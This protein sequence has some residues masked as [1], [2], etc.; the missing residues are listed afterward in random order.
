M[1]FSAI[2]GRPLL[3][4]RGHLVSSQIDVDCVCGSLSRVDAALGGGCSAHIGDLES[5]CMLHRGVMMEETFKNCLEISQNKFDYLWIK[6][7]K[8]LSFTI[9]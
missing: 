3:C 2:T 7:Y 4:G 8:H 6:K 1:G 9:N 5:S